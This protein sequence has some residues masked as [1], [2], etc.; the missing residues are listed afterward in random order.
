MGIRAPLTKP[1]SAWNTRKLGLR[2]WPGGII[3]WWRSIECSPSVRIFDGD[4]GRNLVLFFTSS[5]PAAFC[6]NFEG[7]SSWEQGLQEIYLA[8]PAHSCEELNPLCW[9][10]HS[11]RQAEKSSQ[12]QYDGGLEISEKVVLLARGWSI[13]RSMWNWWL[14]SPRVGVYNTVTPGLEEWLIGGSDP[15]PPFFSL[16]PPLLLTT[17]CLCRFLFLTCFSLAERPLGSFMIFLLKTC[18]YRVFKRSCGIQKLPRSWRLK[19]APL[20][21]EALCAVHLLFILILVIHTPQLWLL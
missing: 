10:R 16:F 14:K 5:G 19:S 7:R 18:V 11:R 17:P 20:Y 13:L 6:S 3:H 2:C 1:Q 4:V 9:K 12:N 21:T 8:S 15:P